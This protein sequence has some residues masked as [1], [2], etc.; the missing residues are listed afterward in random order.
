MPV[1]IHTGLQAGKGKLIDN[2]NPEHLTGIIAQYPDINFVLYHGSFPYGGELS[3][4]AKNY[5]NVYIDMN[6]AWA[7]S[8]TYIRH[9]LNEWLEM[10][11]VNRLIAFGGDAMAVEKRLQR[12]CSCKKHNFRRAFRK[13]K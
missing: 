11:P 12:T 10:I 7:V 8:P 4:I 3:A 1:A 9:H 6:W 13:G 5:R 2:S